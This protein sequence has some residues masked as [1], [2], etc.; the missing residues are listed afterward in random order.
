MELLVYF[1]GPHRRSVRPGKHSTH[2]A[3]LKQLFGQQRK[4]AIRALPPNK[5]LSRSPNMRLSEIRRLGDRRRF[6][7]KWMRTPIGFHGKPRCRRYERPIERA[8][9]DGRRKDSRQGLGE[10]RE[11]VSVLLCLLGLPIRHAVTRLHSGDEGGGPSSRCS[12]EPGGLWSR[13]S[14]R[15]QPMDGS[16]SFGPSITCF[17]HLS[18]GFK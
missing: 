14:Q 9:E 5:Q 7:A 15:F 18:H 11:R 1:L 8:G 16:C 12:R 3:V 13:P 6:G 10:A 4:R 17:G 2:G